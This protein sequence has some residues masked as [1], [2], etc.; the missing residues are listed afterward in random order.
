MHRLLPIVLCSSLLATA[1]SADDPIG[2]SCP[3]NANYTRG[4]A[5]Q[6]N[7]DALLSSLPATA[8]AASTGFATNDTGTSPDQ[9]YGLAQCR[10]DVVNS[11][12]CGVCLNGTA[13]V[14]AASK[15]AG[16]KKATLIFDKC[17]LRLS[18]ERFAGTADAS[19]VVALVN[20]QNATQTEVFTPRLG[21]LM[22]NL[23]RKAAYESPRLF[24]VGSASV[25][26]FVSIYAMAQCT[27]DLGAADC[28]SCLTGAVG[29]IP[30]CCN[31][32]QGGQVI[33]VSCS[34]RFEVSP[35]YNIQAA[36]AA[37]SPAPAPGGGGSV[38]GSDQSRPGSNGEWILVKSHPF[39]NALAS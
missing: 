21:A 30:D 38:N 33:R 35:F 20:T 10:A 23:T 13:R 11:S 17:L 5:F 34:V 32:K 27:R 24:A 1:A 14:L 15:C 2:E 12:D 16:Q 7:L 9:A 18:D 22:N 29:N 19:W 31:G 6:E 26:A 28:Y 25:T 3:S 39:P 36:E 4:S 8:G 37:M